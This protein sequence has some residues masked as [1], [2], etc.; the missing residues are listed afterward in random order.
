MSKLQPA[1]KGFSERRSHSPHEIERVKCDVIGVAEFA[2]RSAFC[3][4]RRNC[5]IGSA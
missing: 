5:I 4:D 2:R 3:Y 1:K